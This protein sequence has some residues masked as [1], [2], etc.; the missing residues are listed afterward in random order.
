MGGAATAL[1]LCSPAPG[2]R[3]A[4]L[5]ASLVLHGAAVAL[6]VADWPRGAPT[7]SGSAAVPV[8][9][10][11]SSGEDAPR[12]ARVPPAAERAAEPPAPAGMSAGTGDDASDPAAPAEAPM[13]AEAAPPIPQSAPPLPAPAAVDPLPEPPPLAEAPAR[14]EAGPHGPEPEQLPAA[15]AD[16][17][18]V[19]DPIPVAAATETPHAAA[20]QAT[21][22]AAT[23]AAPPSPRRAP[24]PARGPNPAPGENVAARPARHAAPPGPAGP[25]AAAPAALSAAAPAEGP[26]LVTSPRYRRPPRPPD[27]PPSALDLGITGTVLVRALV[28][29]EGD[30]QE[31]RVWRSSGHPLLDSAALAAV[32]RWAFEPAR[33]GGRAVPAWVE[34]PIHFRLN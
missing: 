29:P 20:E 34:V 32:R 2:A 17:Q 11:W 15:L 23:T 8:N 26:I 30:T 27:Y 25:P 14:A 22:P 6:L 1:R 24:R 31:T 12:E 21:R 16:V 28:S 5:A 33:N 10:V 19:P 4:P 3:R 13:R 18:P 7:A 9:I